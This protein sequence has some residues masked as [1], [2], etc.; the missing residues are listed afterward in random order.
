MLA[1]SARVV[2]HIMRAGVSLVRGL[3]T[4]LFPSTLASTLSS[5]SSASSPILPFTVSLPAAIATCT[6]CGISMGCLPTRD[7]EKSSEHAAQHFAADI[8]RACLGIAQHAAR[9]G[10]NGNAKPRIDARQF[11]DVGIDA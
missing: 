10:E 7:M 1:T 4:N 6:P 3:T 9:R 11:L 8:G 2:P 5:R